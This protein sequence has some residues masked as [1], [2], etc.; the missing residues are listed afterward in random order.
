MERLSSQIAFA[1]KRIAEAF[2]KLGKGTSEER[3]LH[4]NLTRA[5]RELAEDANCGTYIA[6]RLIPKIYIRKYGIDNLRKYNL[7]GGWRLVYSVEAE[8]ILVLSII[9]E[10]FSHNEYE[11]RFNY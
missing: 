11:R 5:F 10:W 6:A 7:P 8:G 9:L 3:A 4:L 2:R 1:D